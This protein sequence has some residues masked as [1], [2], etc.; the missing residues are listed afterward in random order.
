MNKTVRNLQ[1]DALINDT[2]GHIDIN[3]V[4]RK[5]VFMKEIQAARKELAASDAGL[6]LKL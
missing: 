2:L 5:Q 3:I 1:G 4:T 6:S